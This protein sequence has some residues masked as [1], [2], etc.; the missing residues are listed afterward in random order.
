M[1][2]TDPDKSRMSLLRCENE[3]D[4]ERYNADQL[5]RDLWNR[6]MPRRFPIYLVFYDGR[7]VGFFQ[8]IQQ[9]VV[10]PALH[11]DRMSPRVFLKVVKSL[12][13]EMKRHV[14][15]PIFML[16]DKAEALG[17]KNLRRVR[18]KRAPE[19]AHVYDEEAP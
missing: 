9:T 3:R 1:N 13:T 19:N 8:A 17:P 18:L 7:I 2:Q 16:C 5:S 6:D 14:G 4:L 12:V 10:Y 11:P 15:D